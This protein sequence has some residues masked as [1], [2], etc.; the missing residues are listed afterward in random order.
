[1]PLGLVV[2]LA[3][4]L[5]LRVA[6][7][8][9]N[10]D[11]VCV[12]IYE[13]GTMGNLAWVVGAGAGG[14]PLY[15]FYDNC[16]GHLVTGLLAA[17][18]YALFGPSYLVLKLVPLSL[19]TATLALLW[20]LVDR[21]FDRRAAN[22]TALLFV[23]APLTLAKFSLVA[24]GSHHESV[25]FQVLVLDLFLRIHGA[26][27]RGARLFVA[28]TA[29]GFAVFFY[30]GSVA[31]ILILAS[32][33]IAACGWSKTLADARVALPGFLL[34]SSPLLWVHW[35]TQGRPGHFL[36][37]HLAVPE[38]VLERLAEV[39]RVLPR[40]SGFADLGPIPGR[41]ADWIFFVCFV[42]A[43][44]VLMPRLLQGVRR[45]RASHR[46]GAE[47]GSASSALEAERM[48][49]L[50]LAP[51]LLH[52]PLIVAFF[53]VTR[54]EFKSYAA[55]VEMAQFRYLVPHLSYALVLV[56]L[57]TSAC[58][59]QARRWP[60][61]LGV[62]VG[63]LTA[64]TGLFTLPAVDWCC[65]GPNRGLRYDGFS[66]PLYSRFVLA[67][68]ER[69]VRAA[70]ADTDVVAGILA[71][72][73]PTMRTG[74]YFGL[75]HWAA[76]FRVRPEGGDTA[77][78]LDL[79]SLLRPYAAEYHPDVARGVG[80][81]LRRAVGSSRV[82]QDALGRLL[83]EQNAADPMTLYM[84]EGLCLDYGYPLERKTGDDLF[85]TARLESS[86]PVALRPAWRRGQ[87]IQCGRLLRKGF[88][89]DRE[90]ALGVASS[91]PALER[92]DFWYGVG[93]GLADS[94]AEPPRRVHLDGVP[95]EQRA[96]ALCG[97][98]A[99]LRHAYGPLECARIV[100]PLHA[101]LAPEQ[102]AALER[103]MRWNGYP[104]PVVP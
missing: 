46:H 17:P 37:G 29:A 51:F 10:F 83:S 70:P 21:H 7:L 47:G 24:M 93:W 18:L 76:W 59:S 38:R 27:G 33:H 41:V 63:A 1:M 104:A 81:F 43:W 95:C 12:A 98:G 99:A 67:E 9:T 96:Q 66:A 79:A 54:F 28:A 68:A 34:G 87:G 42:C 73:E 103:G 65:A 14:V 64:A 74:A 72:L 57:A 92:A 2:A 69:R 84:V 8:V 62:A 26:A 39:T 4:F 16:G 100:R 3:L 89:A 85:S 86:I 88:A 32:M 50:L 31:L 80:G 55:P 5:C 101:A 49:A 6:I 52:L 36:A 40:A 60:R 25:F 11:A 77:F 102:R 30:F 15:G 90:K 58:L 56:A 45:V 13:I 82:Q 48:R 61:R 71:G 97:I 20:P 23:L 22:L 35:M 94:C 91:V 44:L 19:G 53:A 75:G 78:D